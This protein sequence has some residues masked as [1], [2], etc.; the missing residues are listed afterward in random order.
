MLQQPQDSLQQPQRKMLQLVVLMLLPVPRLLLTQSA[1]TAL[2]C[3]PSPFFLSYLPPF[4]SLLSPPS[5]CTD[6]SRS[7]VFSTVGILLQSSLFLS[8]K[9]PPHPAALPLFSIFFSVKRFSFTIAVV[10]S[11]ISGVQ[12][13]R[14]PKL[15]NALKLLFFAHLPSL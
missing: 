10:A 9:C 5:A 2:N 15:R 12:K 1:F 6:Q 3:L 8:V 14:E 11:C 13:M 7:P 4:P